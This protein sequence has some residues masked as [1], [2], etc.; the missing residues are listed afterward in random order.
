MSQENVEVVRCLWAGLE[1]DS[2]MPW[3][4]ADR[5]ELDRRLRLDLCDENIEI[6]NPPAFPVADDYD[7]H[8]GVR[9]W[10]TEVWEVFSEL[11][12]ELEELIEAEDA[13]TVVSVQRTQGRMRHTQLEVDLPWAAVWTIR[14]GQAL[15]AQGYMSKA[16]A[17]E[18]AGLRD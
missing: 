4:P 18:A 14:H 7:G 16:E 3:P 17:L 13:E 10:A 1:R 11:H 9:Q 5:D 6:R 12:H 2:G 15:R 8:D